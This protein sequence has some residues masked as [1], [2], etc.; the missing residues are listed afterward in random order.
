MVVYYLSEVHI[1]K[2]KHMNDECMITEQGDLGLGAVQ[3]NED[4]LPN[5]AS[6]KQDTST[7][8]N[9]LN[10]NLDVSEKKSIY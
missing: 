2:E 6:Y 9:K 7:E 1:R 8:S 5:V 10:G 3:I 4:T